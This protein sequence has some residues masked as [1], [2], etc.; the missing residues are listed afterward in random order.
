MTVIRFTEMGLSGTTKQICQNCKWWSDEFTSAC[1]NADSPRCADFVEKDD[2]CEC[3]E[4][5]NDD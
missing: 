5:K 4:V 1:V 2:T 3:F